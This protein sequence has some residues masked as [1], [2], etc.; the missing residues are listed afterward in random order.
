MAT[1]GN[2]LDRIEFDTKN[3]IVV[4]INSIAPNP[5]NPKKQDTP[6]YAK[7][8]ESIHENGLKAPIAVREKKG[9]N[10]ELYEIIDGEQRWRACQ[11]EG[12]TK[13]LI[14]NEGKVNDDKAKAL[15]IWWEQRVP[16]DSVM[17]AKL[18][19]EIAS[20]E[21]INLPYTA[22]EIA[23][24]EK[25]MNFDFNQFSDDKTDKGEFDKNTLKIALSPDQYAVVTQAL[26]KVKKELNCQDA[27][28]LELICAEYLAG[29]SDSDTLDDIIEE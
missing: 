13:V 26:E 3:V 2:K 9:E 8:V 18:V 25:L 10:G 29:F 15:T 28:A 5:W 24:F 22:E 17:E 4:D 1:K 7:V 14:Y 19:T 6:E 27:Y 12:F 23:E 16:F 21:G 11:D 20:V